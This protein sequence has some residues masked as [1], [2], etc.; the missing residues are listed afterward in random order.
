MM[1]HRPTWQTFQIEIT[2]GRRRR[3][4]EKTKKND[5]D[6]SDVDVQLYT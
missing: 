6:E 4:R 2:K 5:D 3:R 1:D